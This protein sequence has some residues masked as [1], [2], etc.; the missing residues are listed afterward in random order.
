M[1]YTNEAGVPAQAGL[2]TPVY[3]PQPATSGPVLSAARCL[4]IL[5]LGLFPLIGLLACLAWGFG[6]TTAPQKRNLA[7]A[8]L[9]LHAAALATAIILL[10][11]W[12]AGLVG[13]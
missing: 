12:V 6:R 7:R 2:Q 11:V 3:A 4:G 5:V 1:P 13:A 8:M 9:W 10:A